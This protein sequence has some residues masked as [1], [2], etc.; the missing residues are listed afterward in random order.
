MNDN[1]NSEFKRIQTKADIVEIINSYVKLE[2]HGKNFFGVCPFHD[3]HSPSMSVSKEKQIYKCFVCGA[4]GNVFTF[5]ENYLGVTFLEAVKIVADKIG[6]NFVIHKSKTKTI[7]SKYY[8]IMNLST[9]FYENNLRT[10]LGKEAREYLVKRGLDEKLQK[11]FSVGLA[12]E[13]NDALY[14]L[15]KKKNIED[16]DMEALGLISKGDNG[17]YDLFRDRIIFPLKNPDGQVNGFSGRVYNKDATSKY[18]NTKETLIFKKRENL[19]NYHLASIEARKEKSV[20]VCEGFMDAIRIYS[21]GLKNVVAT[22]GTALAK[23][24][25]ELLKKLNS[26]VILIMDNDNAGELATLSIGEALLK[27]NIDVGVVRLTG[28]KDPDEYILTYGPTAFKDNVKS[29]MTFIDFLFV[30]LRKDKDLKNPVDLT[31]YIN[32]VIEVISVSPDAILVESCLNKLSE[33]FHLDKDLL[34]DRIKNKERIENVKVTREEKSINEVVSNKK[35]T[36]FDRALEAMVYY[37]MNDTESMKLFIKSNI[38]LPKSKYRLVTNNLLYYFE[39]N[40]EID[41]ADYLTFS[42]G[43]KDVSPVVK[44]I[45]SNIKIT[46]FKIQ[47]MKAALAIVKK[48]LDEA[49]IKEI[50]KE[51]SKELDVSRR[52]KLFEEIL[53]IKRGCVNI[54]EEE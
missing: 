43:Y 32:K 45:I 35:R 1:N 6:E 14:K 41:F 42:E 13:E 19:Y 53:E 21:I 28:K 29:P 47:D 37:M 26:K 40:R 51:I 9:L 50:K 54:N 5:V 49:R 12:L 2:N 27:E 31:N 48:D 52:K 18:I 4:T 22:M 34:R 11:T 10:Q 39:L 36:K 20:L 17:I 16:K 7:N 30:S 8:D 23:E 25:V 38:E 46:S 33:E 24:Q 44:E 3:D 15:L